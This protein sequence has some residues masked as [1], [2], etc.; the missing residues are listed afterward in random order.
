[1][2]PIIMLPFIVIS[3]TFSF[4]IPLQLPNSS[5]TFL[6]LQVPFFS[7]FKF[8]LCSLLGW[9]QW[10]SFFLWS[11]CEALFIKVSWWWPPVTIRTNTKGSVSEA[12]AKL[13]FCL[14]EWDETTCGDSSRQRIAVRPEDRNAQMKSAVKGFEPGLRSSGWSE[15]CV[16]DSCFMVTQ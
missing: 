14:S 2:Q 5:H 13:A 11:K 3:L 10:D 6:L 16:G 12:R 9:F 8:I 15:Q 7:G 1:M 4:F